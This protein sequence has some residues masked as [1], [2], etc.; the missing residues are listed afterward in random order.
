[1]A[2]TASRVTVTTSATLIAASDADGSSVVVRNPV[3]GATVDVGPAAVASGSGFQLL[4]G[5]SVA[6][7]L[8]PGE[9]L[10]GIAGSGTQAI[11]V[12]GSRA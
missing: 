2:I 4:A 3:G 7:D 9:T 8:A 12:L 6:L 1:M 5:E 11:H 10:Y